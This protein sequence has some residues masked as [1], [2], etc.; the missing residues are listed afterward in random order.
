MPFWIDYKKRLGITHN[1]KNGNGEYANAKK[2]LMKASYLVP[3]K[4]G[5]K[6]DYIFY[7]QS[8]FDQQPIDEFLSQFTVKSDDVVR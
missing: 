1:P 4:D 5:Q 6:N 2:N 8:I 7:R 3:K